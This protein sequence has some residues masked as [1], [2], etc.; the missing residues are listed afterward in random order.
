MA[1]HDRLCDYLNNINIY[2]NDF[3]YDEYY[4]LNLLYI[5]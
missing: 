1:T 4:K 3:E 5:I 2:L